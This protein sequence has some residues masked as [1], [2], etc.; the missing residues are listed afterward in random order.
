MTSYFLKL[1]PDKTYLLLIDS[2]QNTSIFFV[3]NVNIAG[4]LVQ[5]ST[6]VKNRSI[7]FDCPLSFLPHISICLLSPHSVASLCQFLNI[8][9]AETLVYAFIT[10]Q[11]IPNQLINKFQYIQ[12]STVWVLTYTRNL[13][14]L[15]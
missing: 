6:T 2:P 11:A 8:S 4:V 13:P 1:N 9:D 12:N 10:A 3:D 15:L 5:P 14:T 7:I